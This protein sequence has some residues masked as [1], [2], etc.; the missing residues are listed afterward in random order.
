MKLRW[1]KN[2]FKKRYNT[3]IITVQHRQAPGYWLIFLKETT[4]KC[5]Y[6][7]TGLTCIKNYFKQ[8]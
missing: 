3:L 4:W 1:A 2:C 6:M 8:D 5:F 7:A